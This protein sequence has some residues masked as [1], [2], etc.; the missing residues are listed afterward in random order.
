VAVGEDAVVETAQAEGVTQ[1][2]LGG[3]A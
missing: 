2:G 3:G 1:A